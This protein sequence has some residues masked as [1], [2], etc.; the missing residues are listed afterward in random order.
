MRDLLHCCVLSRLS[1]LFPEVPVL[2]AHDFF[3]EQPR[4]WATSSLARF[5]PEL[6]PPLFSYP[7]CKASATQALQLWQRDYG[8]QF[9]QFRIPQERHHAH[10]LKILQLYKSLSSRRLQSEIAEESQHHL[11]RP[12]FCHAHVFSS[13]EHHTKLLGR[14]VDRRRRLLLWR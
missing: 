12:A 11:C 7:F 5:C 9:H 3:S 6:P 1:H 8:F 10:E 4:V 13:Q 14:S 2:F